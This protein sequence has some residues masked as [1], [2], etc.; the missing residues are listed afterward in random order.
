[1]TNLFGWIFSLFQGPKPL[2]PN[3]H[4]AENASATK[5]RAPE[6]GDRAPLGAGKQTAPM[7]DEGRY[8]SILDYLLE[9]GYAAVT[10][11]GDIAAVK[12]RARRA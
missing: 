1:M 6:S 3:S 2:S 8:A 10:P 9:H 4:A 12:R 11:D 7:P 5:D